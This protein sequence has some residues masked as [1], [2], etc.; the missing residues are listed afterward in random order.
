MQEI[1]QEAKGGDAGVAGKEV[2]A[3]FDILVFNLL[4]V[5]FVG[6]LQVKRFTVRSGSC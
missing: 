5:G 4:K 6:L 1:A 2:E 3:V